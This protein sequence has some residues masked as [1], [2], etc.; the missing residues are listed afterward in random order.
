M[1]KLFPKIKLSH[2]DLRLLSKD[3]SPWKTPSN[4]KVDTKSIWLGFT[5]DPFIFENLL[6]QGVS[7][8]SKVSLTFFISKY[9]ESTSLSRLDLFVK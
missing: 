6:L 4:Q 1:Y 9:Q 8:H 3:F 2:S 5:E 7:F